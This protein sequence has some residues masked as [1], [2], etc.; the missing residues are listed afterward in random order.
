LI[1][2]SKWFAAVTVSHFTTLPNLI[3]KCRKLFGGMQPEIHQ[4]ITLFFY[5]YYYKKRILC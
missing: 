2:I 5:I 3:S 1:V 4:V